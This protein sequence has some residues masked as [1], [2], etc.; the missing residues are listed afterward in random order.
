MIGAQILRSLWPWLLTRRG[1]KVQREVS[2]IV[3]ISHYWLQIKPWFLSFRLYRRIQ[4]NNWFKCHGPHLLLSFWSL[5]ILFLSSMVKGA[6][7]HK[8]S[9]SFISPPTFVKAFKSVW[10]FLRAADALRGDLWPRWS[11]PVATLTWEPYLTMPCST[12][13]WQGTHTL[14]TLPK[15]PSPR[16]RQSW[17][18]IQASIFSSSNFPTALL[19]HHTRRW[20]HSIFMSAD[21]M[22][23]EMIFIF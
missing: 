7:P 22:A 23:I 21:K 15:H 17:I 13:V 18:S 11:R 2:H 12:T 14:Q 9:P 4:D 19:R 5:L 10:K 6:T 1:C 8:P 20:Q 16:G 3:S